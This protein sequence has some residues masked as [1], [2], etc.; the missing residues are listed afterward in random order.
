MSVHDEYV[1][2]LAEA[3]DRGDDTAKLHEAHLSLVNRQ[4]ELRRVRELLAVH[5]YFKSFIAEQANKLTDIARRVEGVGRD[6]LVDVGRLKEARDSR[7]ELAEALK[8]VT[9]LASAMVQMSQQNTLPI[10]SSPVKPE[11]TP[12]FSE[13]AETYLESKARDYKNE[14]DVRV[15]R[16]TFA[17]FL[18]VM[19]D[20]PIADYNGQDA[21][22]FIETLRRIPKNYGKSNVHT[23]V[24]DAISAA[25]FR[26]DKGDTIDRMSDVTVEKRITFISGLWEFLLPLEHVSR[27]IWKGF[28]FRTETVRE[29]SDWSEDNLIRLT[30]HRFVTKTFSRQ[31]FAF[32]TSIAA[33]SGM[34]QSEICHLR[35]DD[36]VHTEDG[37][38]MYVQEHDPVEVDGKL[39]KFSP[40]TEAGE[41]V[42]PVH[43]ELVKVGLLKHVERMKNLGQTF[44]FR[45]LKPSGASN[46]LSPRFQQAFSRHKKA[47]G[48]T[49]ENVFHSF[50][51]S[52]S[53]ILR[54]EDATIREVWIDAVL[55]HLGDTSKKSQGITTYLHKIG[56]KNLKKTISRIHYPESFKIASLF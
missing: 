34:R 49:D 16:N 38:V 3:L 50:R 56:T 8:Q 2:L 32:I 55:G 39:V 6:Q 36:F 24:L 25:D 22:K 47:A 5:S 15:L 31:T 44:I 37:W 18:E 7:N 40:K 54:N 13:L 23:P 46:L 10:V 26:E 42:V 20:K 45:D 51:H 35:C 52:V 1:R 14:K 21:H 17:L 19:G 11:N 43:P 27:N 53:T 48:V 9:T 4:A 28:K 41:R 33:Y 12:M 30:N 29:V